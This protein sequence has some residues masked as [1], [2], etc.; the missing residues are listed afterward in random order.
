MTQLI[1]K[2]ALLT[3]RLYNMKGVL[4]FPL[5]C[6]AFFDLLESVIY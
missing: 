3:I 4:A 2:I 6:E 5:C 1:Y